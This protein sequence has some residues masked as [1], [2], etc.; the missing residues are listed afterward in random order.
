MLEQY[1]EKYGDL[2]RESLDVG[3]RAARE[4]RLSGIVV[5]IHNVEFYL[6]SPPF[7]RDR[8]AIKDELVRA[9]VSSLD[10]RIKERVERG[11][12]ETQHRDYFENRGIQE[13]LRD[14]VHAL[15]GLAQFGE[16][17]TSSTRE[18]LREGI[19]RI[20]SALNDRY[21][22]IADSENPRAHVDISLDRFVNGDLAIIKKIAEQTGIKVTEAINGLANTLIRI[23]YRRA[24]ELAEHTFTFDEIL[25]EEVPTIKNIGTAC[26]IN[27][28]ETI[29]QLARNVAEAHYVAALP[30]ARSEFLFEKD[31]QNG[32]IPNLRK[33]GDEYGISTKDMVIDL[34][35]RHIEY[36]KELEIK[37][38]HPTE[39]TDVNLFRPPEESL[40]VI[41][42]ISDLGLKYKLIGEA[43]SAVQAIR[44]VMESTVYIRDRKAL[45]EYM[46]RKS[47]RM[48]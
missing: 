9:T 4:A 10:E 22:R 44:K 17:Y 39:S 26:N 35:R 43:A 3:I 41:A 6:S 19:S 7:L 21:S 48:N 5:A 45:I 34:V 27:V 33:L 11:V 25:S 15:V 14:D 38:I 8:E 32:Y 13:I 42:K 23:R 29:K 40:N 12:E 2:L 24:L 1:I 47:P 18:N 30:Y 46:L 31:V 16:H 20:I 37:R 28:R 36:L